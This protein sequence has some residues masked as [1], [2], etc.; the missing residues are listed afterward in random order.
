M[1]MIIAN[2]PGNPDYVYKHLTHAAWNGLHFADLG[3]P[4]FLFIVGISLVFSLGKRIKR[5]EK[6]GQLY[7]KILSRTAIIFGLGV[8]VDF[9]PFISVDPFQLSSFISLSTVMGVLQRIAL[10]YFFASII[11]LSSKNPMIITIWIFVLLISHQIVLMQ[12]PIPDGQERYF[13]SF[14]GG[15]FYVIIQTISA[16]VIVLFGVMGG[17]LLRQSDKL[18]QNSLILLTAGLTFIILALGTSSICPIIK[19]ISTPT[20]ILITAGYAAVVFCFFYWLIEIRTFDKWI[21]PFTIFGKNAIS[22]FVGSILLAKLIEI[23]ML[24]ERWG[25]DG[26]NIRELIYNQL[27]VLYSDAYVASFLYSLLVMTLWLVLMKV[28]HKHNLFIKV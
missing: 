13:K 7:K 28:L 12:F 15:E 20:F 26:R 3:V 18:R 6:Q 23:I 11:Y 8:F 16:T 24:P 2:N 5:E 27:L 25:L 22:V 9:F 17:I 1:G 4:A 10:G 21:L 19:D 14:L